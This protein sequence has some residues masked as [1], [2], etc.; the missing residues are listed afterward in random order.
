ML[1]IRCKRVRD[2]EVLGAVI[3]WHAPDCTEVK[4]RLLGKRRVSAGAEVDSEQRIDGYDA[5][6][7]EGAERD[8]RP[9]RKRP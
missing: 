5:A 4:T 3:M 2:L 7:T 9:K 1:Q 6:A 8:S